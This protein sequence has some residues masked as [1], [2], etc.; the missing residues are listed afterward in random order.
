M[1]KKIL[2]TP[3]GSFVMMGQSEADMK[4]FIPT[5]NNTVVGKNLIIDISDEDYE[6]LNHAEKVIDEDIVGTNVVMR[7]QDNPPFTKDGVQ[8]TA[9][10]ENQTQMDEDIT[11]TCARL[12]KALQKGNFADN[13]SFQQRIMD[14]KTA[15]QGIDTSSISF[16]INK[17][18]ERYF[19]DAGLGTP[20]NKHNL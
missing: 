11:A 9:W 4:C 19:T 8:K 17:T 1:A 10:F 3:T 6:S 5:W 14:Y 12:D 20:I 13:A 2:K 16:P 7:D 18:L 15:L